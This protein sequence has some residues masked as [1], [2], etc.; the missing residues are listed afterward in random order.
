MTEEEIAEYVPSFIEEGRIG[1][2]GELKI[3]PTAKATEIMLLNKTEWDAFCAETGVTADGLS[4]KEKLVE[5][6]RTYYEWTDAKTPD[7]PGDGKSFYGTD[8]VANL[9][10]IGAMQQGV[11][12]FSVDKGQVTLHPDKDEMCIRDRCTRGN[13][14]RLLPLKKEFIQNTKHTSMLSK[15]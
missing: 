10:I 14:G 13:R 11:E 9:F 7:V 4:T 8:A 12:L 2:N 5:T 6:A 15:L 1:A 3:F